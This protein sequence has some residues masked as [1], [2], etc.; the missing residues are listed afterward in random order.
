M[1][2]KKAMRLFHIPISVIITFTLVFSA[3]AQDSAIKQEQVSVY[4]GTPIVPDRLPLVEDRP[5]KNVIFIIGDGTGLVQLTTGQYNLVGPAGRLYAQTLPVTGL[6]KTYA[7]DNLITDS[8]SGATAFSCGVKTDNGM[9]GQLPDGRK[10]K[11]ILEMAEEKG[12]S[13]G[14]VATSTVTHA[15]P[16]SYA[17]HIDSRQRQAEIADQYVNAGVEVILGGGYEYFIPSSEEGSSRKDNRDLT[18]EFRENGYEYVQTADEM[19]R[20][21][22]ERL[23][24]LFSESGMPSEQRAPT[25]AEMSQKAIDVLSR[26]EK[27]FFLMIEGSQ[28]DWAGHGNDAQYTVRE[29]KDFDAAIK[30]AL[31]FA[32]ED[33]ETLVVITADHET[34]GMTLQDSNRDDSEIT[35]A[36]TTG[37]HTGVPVPLMAYGPHA[38]EFTG[39][40]E[41]TTVGKKVAEITG[42]G[43]LPT[44]ID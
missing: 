5:V 12:L 29:V 4:T 43:V 14:L 9:I 2:R 8:A 41:N 36:W 27:G 21:D 7:A 16:A 31:D 40:W 37:S 23:L 19:L 24:G 44:I 15:T 34:G 13:T 25:L 3:C 30:T 20:S 11:T 38:I 28:I 1:L 6:V 32:V 26:N 18:M 22:S 39:W 33:G 42:W 10:C 35:I 17:A